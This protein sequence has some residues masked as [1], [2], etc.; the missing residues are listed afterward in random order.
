[1]TETFTSLCN[2]P[3]VYET[4]RFLYNGPLPNVEDLT[5]EDGN[6]IKYMAIQDF[7]N[8]E[9]SPFAEY[10]RIALGKLCQDY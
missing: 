8:P 5:P 6:L 7:L 3:V 4:T 1:M 2:G 9:I 10:N